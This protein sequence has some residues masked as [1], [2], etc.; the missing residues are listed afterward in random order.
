MIWPQCIRSFFSLFLSHTLSVSLFL[1]RF[2]YSTIVIL[3]VHTICCPKAHLINNTY[4]RAK[5][6]HTHT[7]TKNDKNQYKNERMQLTKSKIHFCDFGRFERKLL[8]PFK[9]LHVPSFG[10]IFWNK[11]YEQVFVWMKFCF[12][13]SELEYERCMW[14]KNAGKHTFTFPFT[15]THTHK[16]HTPKWNTERGNMVFGNKVSKKCWER[17]SSC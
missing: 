1:Y 17:D 12:V 9:Y 16:M 8:N 4:T 7:R 3:Y 2:R 5:T 15:R 10:V 14:R 11:I 6:T 13:N